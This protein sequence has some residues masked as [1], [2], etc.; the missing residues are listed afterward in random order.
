MLE[1][2]M[3]N[4]CFLSFQQSLSSHHH[5]RSSP[6][7]KLTV[8]ITGA[9]GLV[10]SRLVSR[11]TAEGHSVRVLTRNP[12]SAKGKFAGMRN[13][14][15]FGPNEWSQALVVSTSLYHYSRVFPTFESRRVGSREM[16][17]MSS[18]YKVQ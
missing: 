14:S 9:T 5:P 10:G 12:T 8:A 17:F 3:G 15:V 11:L 1:T 16:Q 6:G 2:T 7:D 18:L 4:S 13:V